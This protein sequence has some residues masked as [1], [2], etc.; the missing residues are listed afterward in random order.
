MNMSGR[1]LKQETLKMTFDHDLED[2]IHIEHSKHTPK[3]K[4]RANYLGNYSVQLY[5]YIL[6]SDRTI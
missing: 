4:R 1:N 5:Q 3:N 2:K 6:S